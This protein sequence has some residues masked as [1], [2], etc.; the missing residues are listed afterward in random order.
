M[1]HEKTS[2]KEDFL[3]PRVA[4]GEELGI[5][6]GLFFILFE[7]SILKLYPGYYLQFILF[8]CLAG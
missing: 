5:Y 7:F 8:P 2:L 4:H 1:G 3:G 6:E